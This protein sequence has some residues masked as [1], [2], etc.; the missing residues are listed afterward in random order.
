MLR[1]LE[2]MCIALRDHPNA[3]IPMDR[4]RLFDAPILGFMGRDVLIYGTQTVYDAP[5]DSLVLRPLPISKWG[6]SAR[7][8]C[9]KTIAAVE[10]PPTVDDFP[11]DPARDVCVGADR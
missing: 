5:G 8:A 6:A 2:E 4:E 1:N 3:W 7:N 10:H 11:I 9:A